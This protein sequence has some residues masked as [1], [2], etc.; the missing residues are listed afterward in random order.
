MI[1]WKFQRIIVGISA[2]LLIAKFIAYFITNSVGVYSDA[3]ESIV[4]VIAG[5]ISLISLRWAAKPRDERHPFGHGKME[6]ISASIEGSLI[7]LAGGL[8]I[9][10]A[11][12]RFFIQPTQLPE[13]EVGMVIIAF[14][15]VLNYLLGVWS[16]KKGKK[17]SSIALV[18]GGKHLQ[19]DTYS[20]IGLL[21]GLILIKITG[22]ILLDS[23]LAFVYG[24]IIIITGLRILSKTIASLV[25]ENDE[26][27]L[28]IIAL[29]IDKYKEEN[30][31]NIHNLRVIR[32]G[33]S[34]HLDCDLT[35]PCFY[36]IQEGHKVT[37]NLKQAVQREN[38]ELYFT[39]HS[40]SCD[41][42]YCYQCRM[43]DCKLRKEEC[44]EPFE[45]S[46]GNLIAIEND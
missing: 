35:L 31:I 13:L 6:L 18:A 39:V 32:Y 17:S 24:G 41:Q 45:F 11:V 4:N 37:E 36:T 22:L 10:E 1:N 40:D 30:W 43:I 23:L 42:N 16:I 14:T 28:K 44:R 46:V 38:V 3:M 8:I 29:K 15:G 34:L 27:E 19:S 20:T 33:N 25:D 7:I 5:A 12:K 2:L 26:D 21:V 9:Y